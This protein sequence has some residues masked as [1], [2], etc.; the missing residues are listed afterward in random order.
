M[1]GANCTSRAIWGSV[2]CSRTPDNL[3]YLLGAL[4]HSQ[5]FNSKFPACSRITFSKNI[6][7]MFSDNL[8]MFTKSP[9]RSKVF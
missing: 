5:I 2:S 8:K 1:Q 9:V 7:K 4:Q 6:T 3:L